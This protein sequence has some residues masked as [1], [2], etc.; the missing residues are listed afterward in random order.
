MD[1]DE[2]SNRARALV[3]VL[4]ERSAETEELRRL[5]P[6]TIRD[7]TD[8]SFFRAVVPLE[9]GGAALSASVVCDVG[10]ELAKG[11]VSTGWVAA[12]LMGHNWLVAQF[13]EDTQQEVFRDGYML[14][15]AALS[16]GP[17][18]RQIDNG[19]SVSGRS[20]W[21]SGVQHSE[22]AM[23]T[24]IVQDDDANVVDVR[25]F[26][27]PMAA[28]TI[29]DVWH[30]DGM[31]GTGSN[32]IVTDDVFVPSDYSISLT[33]LNSLEGTRDI[34]FIPFLS[35]IAAGPA[36]GAAEAAVAGFVERVEQRV[37][38]YTLGERAK[39]RPIA[40][41]RIG[42]AISQLRAATALFDSAVDEM[43]AGPM[44]Q[45]DAAA[46]RL[47]GATVVELSRLCVADC[48]AAAGG[49][50]HFLSEPMQRIQRD[51]NTL[52]GHAIFDMDRAAEASGRLAVGFPA[53]P[54]RLL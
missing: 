23:V 4:A 13:P 49:S 43:T 24:G 54:M 39:E 41:M 2:L 10:R 40:Q 33:K 1:A 34:S 32:T 30:T 29:D 14:G 26:L 37:M 22:W 11:C 16:P 53:D 45:A 36:L 31:R 9:H 35:L 28:A 7:L 38:A 44:S 6:D 47:D 46:I 17:V 12:F 48:C 50:I 25:L 5:S 52:S 19:Y 15:A 20:P 21:A 8:G 3:A 51:I 27:L 18:A 42:R